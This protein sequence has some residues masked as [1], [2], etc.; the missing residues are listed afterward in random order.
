[1]FRVINKNIKKQIVK[2]RISNRVFIPYIELGLNSNRK[3]GNLPIE[4]ITIG[5]KNNLDIAEMGL[6]SFLESEGYYKIIIKKSKIPL[7]Y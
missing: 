2:H 7:R 6:R 1:M 5:P 4:K 3:E